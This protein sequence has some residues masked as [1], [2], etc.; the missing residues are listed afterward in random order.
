MGIPINSLS[1]LIIPRGLKVTLYENSDYTG[2]RLVLRNNVSCLMG[3]NVDGMNFNDKTSSMIVEPDSEAPPPPPPLIGGGISTVVD[4]PPPPPPGPSLK[5][6]ASIASYESCGKGSIYYYIG[7]KC[8]PIASLPDGT[9]CAQNGV[10]NSVSCGGGK[11]IRGKSD[12][13]PSGKVYSPFGQKCVPIT[14]LPTG[15]KCS[16]HVVCKSELCTGVV[17]SR[18][19]VSGGK[20]A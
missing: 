13:C 2:R 18:G 10:C 9:K 15:A 11:C 6:E 3:Y 8:I 1:A 5:N 14:S 19:R 4:P 7:K 17:N 16:R 20:C 12:Y